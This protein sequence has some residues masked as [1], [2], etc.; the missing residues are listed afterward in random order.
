ML[1]YFFSYS[2]AGHVV[3][4]KFTTD[5]VARRLSATLIETVNHEFYKLLGHL[6]DNKHSKVSRNLALILR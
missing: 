6:N 3:H 5:I 1:N 2:E 4:R